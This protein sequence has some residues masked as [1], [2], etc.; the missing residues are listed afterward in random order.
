MYKLSFFVPVDH[1]EIVKQ[2]VFNTGAGRLG[3]YDQCSWEILG[4]GQFR[5]LEGSKPFIGSTDQLER[6]KE[7]KVEVI[8]DDLIISNA[9]EALTL[10]HP[11]EEPAYEVVKLADF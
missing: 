11:Y 8:C 6:V 9:V 3:N 10:A 2:A 4:A 7:Y 1:L 5:P